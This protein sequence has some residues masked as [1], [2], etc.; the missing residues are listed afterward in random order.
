MS[1]K[2]KQKVE[3]TRDALHIFLTVAFLMGI[4][5]PKLYVLAALRW[6]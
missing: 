3:L 5:V 4:I 2:G 1:G 6:N